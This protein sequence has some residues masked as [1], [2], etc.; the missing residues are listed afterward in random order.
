M[1]QS[2]SFPVPCMYIFSFHYIAHRLRVTCPVSLFHDCSKHRVLVHYNN[3]NNNIDDDAS[4]NLG[5]TWRK[6]A[7]S[8]YQPNRNQSFSQ[9]QTYILSHVFLSDVKPT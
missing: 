3:R 8:N 5:A 2:I 4:N 7:S 6:V 1:L 9:L